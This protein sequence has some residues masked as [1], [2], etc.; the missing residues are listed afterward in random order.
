LIPTDVFD[1]LTALQTTYTNL[2]TLTTTYGSGITTLYD[3]LSS[4]VTSYKQ[5]KIADIT[6]LNSL[7]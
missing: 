7:N 4:T 1:T 3:T 6:D 2:S 5:A